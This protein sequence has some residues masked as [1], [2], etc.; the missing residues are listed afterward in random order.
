VPLAEKIVPKAEGRSVT[1]LGRSHGHRCGHHATEGQSASV[2]VVYFNSIPCGEHQGAAIACKR[3]EVDETIPQG[4][5]WI[6]LINPT[7]EEDRKVED[8]VGGPV[9]TKSDPDYTEPLEARSYRSQAMFQ[10][11]NEQHGRMQWPR[12]IR[13]RKKLKR[14]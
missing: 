2:I 11:V 5:I 4:A 3:L 12:K 6:D 14:S 9:P 7:V 8:F 1:Q 13:N 10:A